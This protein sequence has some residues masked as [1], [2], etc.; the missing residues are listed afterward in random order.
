[1]IE[2]Y[3][4]DIFAAPIN[5]LIH[6]ANCFH[7][8]GAGI[9]KNIKL[10]YPRAYNA[11][12]LTVR[13]DRKKLGQFSVALSAED[14]P[15]HIL[16]L[17]TQHRYGRDKQYVEYDKFFEAIKNAKEWSEKMEKY[18]VI[19]CPFNISCNNAGGDW[20]GKILPALKYVFSDNDCKLLIC[21]I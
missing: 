12:L 9:A 4:G 11:D 13:G 15:F 5:I 20:N 7:T 2:F 6:S 18:P 8:M 14:Q 19:G 21:E 16:N 10:K 17:Y 1:M 3:K